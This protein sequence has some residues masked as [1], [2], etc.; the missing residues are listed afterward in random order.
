MNRAAAVLIALGL[1]VFAADPPSD[2]AVLAVLKRAAPDQASFKILR[3][4]FV[5][6]DLDLVIALASPKNWPMTDGRFIVWTKSHKL[7]LFLQEKHFP[8]RV[9]EL[10]VEP[11]PEN[12]VVRIERVTTTD[13]VIA[14][15]GDD[16][17]STPRNYKYV[18]DVRAKAM[19]SH[20]AYAPFMTHRVFASGAGAVFVGTDSQ[21]LVA[22]AFDPNRTPPLRVLDDA[23]ARRWFSRI[24]VSE[25]TVGMERV[26]VLYVQPDEFQPVKF[27]AFVLDREPGGSFGPRLLVTETRGAKTLRYELPQSS[28]D[29][30]AKARRLRVKDNYIRA[31]TE[32][33]ERIGPWQIADGKLWFGKT[34]Y[35]GE[36]NSGVG[37]F[38]YFDPATRKYRL[39]VPP[40]IADWS[41]TAIV[42]EPGAVWT[43][44]AHGGEYGGPSGGV[45]RFDPQSETVSK[46]Y[47]PDFARDFLRVKDD[48]LI[49]TS[50]GIAVLHGNDQPMRYFVDRT[51]DGRLR[52]AEATGKL[53]R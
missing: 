34:F 46:F 11:G 51:T 13:A 41:V 49:A 24:S 29:A 33:D 20:F 31:N 36:G 28:F 2:Q 32:F 27:G 1:A 17:Q 30:F 40:E 39:F 52:I 14:C 18:Y 22:V 7:G 16:V 38:G 12:C 26:R 44:L 25:G 37:G 47:L 3:R 15:T 6:D 5:T 35:D 8:S 50:G 23:E 43:G 48:L 45:L 10:A 9:F 53:S 19:I 21:R 42:V 4:A